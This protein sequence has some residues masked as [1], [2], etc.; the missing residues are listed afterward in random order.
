MKIEEYANDFR[1]LINKVMYDSE[2]TKE[3]MIKLFIQEIDNL[4][5]MIDVINGSVEK[6][7]DGVIEYKF[8]NELIKKYKIK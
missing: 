5:F 8:T 1:D 7:S 6:D 3:N 4:Q 2:L